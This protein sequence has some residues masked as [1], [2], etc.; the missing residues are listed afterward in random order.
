MTA[1]YFAKGRY[2]FSVTMSMDQSAQINVLPTVGE[3]WDGCWGSSYGVDFLWGTQNQK[4]RNWL[5]EFIPASL[6]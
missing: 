4:S 6:G 5:T 2:A 1:H 3:R